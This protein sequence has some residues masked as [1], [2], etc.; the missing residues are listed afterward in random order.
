MWL[1]K[2]TSLSVYF[3]LDGMQ[4]LIFE[5]GAYGVTLFIILFAVGIVMNVPGL[6]F[7]IIGFMLYGPYKGFLIV[8]VGSLIAVIAH[9]VFARSLAGEALGEIKQPF[10]RKQMEKLKTKP[11][12]TSVILRLIFYVSPPV[13]YAFALSPIRTK[14]FII[15]SAISLPFCTVLYHAIAKLLM[16]QIKFW[17]M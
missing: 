16:E 5:A 2:Y 7:L 15:G 12:I 13:N 4:K 8:Y 9:F 6:L 17:F 14:D 1:A 3:S 10:I 11:I